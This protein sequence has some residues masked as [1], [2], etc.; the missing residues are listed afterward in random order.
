MPK[1]AHVGK[2]RGVEQGPAQGCERRDM[3]DLHAAL[4]PTGDSAMATSREHGSAKSLAAGMVC[5][6]P[7]K[8]DAADAGHNDYDFPGLLSGLVGPEGL[9]PPTKAL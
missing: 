6:N 4:A 3:R 5:K 2:L 9:E 7:R 8:S 1:T